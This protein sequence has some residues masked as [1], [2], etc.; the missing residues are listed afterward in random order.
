MIFSTQN[1]FNNFLLFIFFGFTAGIIFNLIKIIFLKN[2]I[3]LI[4]ENLNNKK[5]KIFAENKK[6]KTK[7]KHHK[8]KTNSKIKSKILK[9]IYNFTLDLIFFSFFS[10]FFAYLINFFNLGK[11][12]LTLLLAYS[13]GIIWINKALNKLVANLEN[14]W[15][16]IINKISS[17]IREKKIAKHKTP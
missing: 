14:K 1:Q 4:F 16:N 12:T 2:N 8:N 15:Y 6:A 5:E 17:T 13:L 10:C 11:L 3:N 7:N 9:N